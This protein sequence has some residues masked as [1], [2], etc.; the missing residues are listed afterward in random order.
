MT[1]P[2]AEGCDVLVVGGGV[3]G[4]ALAGEL[5]RRAPSLRIVLWEKE[6]GLGRH[7]S[8]RNSGVLHSGIYY[9]P[10]T[11][12][13][14]LCADGSRR[15]AAF[16]RENGIAVGAA[17]KVILAT[18]AADGP[19][20]ERLLANARANNV[21]AERL[22]EAGVRALEPHAA[23]GWGGIH[24]PDTA[25]LDPVEILT[26]LAEKLRAAG[27]SLRFG[28][29]LA[30]VD[31]DK[32]LAH[33]TDG[34]RLSYR[35]LVNAA[36]AH[37]DRVARLFGFGRRHVFV[38]FKGLYRQLPAARASLVRSLIYPV[39]DARFPFLG[40]H[41]TRSVHGDVY[42]GPTAVPALGRENYGWLAGARPVEALGTLARLAGLW[43]K[44]AGGFRGLVGE[45]VKRFRVEG[46]WQAA[47][48][49][50]PDLRREDL[51][52]CGKV[53]IRPQ[54]VDLAEGRLEMDYV[55]EG[56]GDSF[57][58][59]NAISPAFTCALAYAPWAVEEAGLDKALGR[60]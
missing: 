20:L 39:P 40:V 53:G 47:R 57:H 60:V 27:V 10:H 19:G 11:L 25:V 32:R 45:E 6:P 52:P 51:L 36:G 7:A 13:A 9:P 46:I 42:V 59:L 29:G 34:S 43:W 49:M 28:T 26:A 48:R 37:A 2:A 12:K 14:R 41:F 15:M 58:V 5:A 1:A 4:L 30:R 22:D 35:F 56:D 8:G 21:R 55:T 17:G 16:A 3:I 50:V 33:G 38:P 18:S 31:P 24:C 44:N 54:L 23:G